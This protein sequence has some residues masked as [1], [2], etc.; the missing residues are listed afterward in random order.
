MY[1][2]LTLNKIAKCGMDK[3]PAEN[4]TYGDDIKNPDAI[5]LR[6]FNMHEM[7]LPESLTA[8]ARAG[9]GVNNIP[10][11]KCSE[12]GIVVFN[13]PGANANAVKELVI[14][15]LFLSSRKI[16]AGANWASTLADEGDN[17]SKVVEKGKSAFAGPEIAGKKLGVIGLG[18]IGVKVAN[19]ASA[20]D[21]EVMGYDPFLSVNAAW[22]LSR[23]II[24]ASSAKEIFETCDYITLHLPLNDST[25]GMV[26][27]ETLAS[28]KDGVRILNFAR[29]GLVDTDALLAAIESGKV[30]SYVTDFPDAKMIGNES[31]IAIPHLG[32]STPESE[33]NCAM[34]AAEELKEY[35]ENGN[36]INSVN[37]PSCVLEREAKTR[38]C[39]LHKNIPNMLGQV[40]AF[41]A[42]KNINITN[43]LNKSKGEN[44]YTIVETDEHPGADVVEALSAIDGIIK[45]RVID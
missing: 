8:V 21:M 3:L 7:E 20:L 30:A 25:K 10:L 24:K 36:I 14:A 19:A 41:F 18:A 16:I 2:V 28:M 29:G 44:A 33:D 43:M 34:M 5:I 31:I 40:S 4:Y 11:D 32:A 26:G 39:V 45:V 9:A 38:V 6:S 15:S 35:L 37:F 23:A 42:G 1:N 22:G 12:K 13:T 27:A 17:I